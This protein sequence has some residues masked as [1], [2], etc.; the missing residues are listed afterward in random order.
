M[1][2]MDIRHHSLFDLSLV[3]VLALGVG[4]SSGGTVL[5]QAARQNA[6]ALAAKVATRAERSEQPEGPHDLVPDSV[7][8]NTTAAGATVFEQVGEASFYDKGF[9][10]IRAANGEKF[11]QWKRTAA[12]PT[13]PLGTHA[14]VTNLEN[15]KAVKVQ[16]TDRGPYAKGRDLDL[17]KRAAKEIGLAKKEGEIPVKIEAVVPPAGEQAASRSSR[18]CD[19]TEGEEGRL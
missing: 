14:T 15:E 8:T 12:H 19:R 4:L 9:R 2:S 13:L 18:R 6:E 11:D 5:G 10:G 3:G 16:I 7:T 1:L 17:S